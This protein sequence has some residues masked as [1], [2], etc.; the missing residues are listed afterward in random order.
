M[1]ADHDHQLDQREAG[2]GGVDRPGDK[3][4]SPGAAERDASAHIDAPPLV[5]EQRA[6]RRAPRPLC[7]GAN[8]T[9]V[10][11]LLALPA[12]RSPPERSRA[13]FF[14]ALL[15]LVMAAQTVGLAGSEAL[16]LAQLSARQ[17]PLAFVIASLAAVVGLG[18]LRGA[19]RAAR[20]DCAVRGRCCS[21]R[22]S[23]LVAVA[24]RHARARRAR[25]LRTDRRVL[26]DAL[27]LHEPLLDLRRRLLRHADQQAAR[28]RVRARLER[29]GAARRRARRGR[30]ARGRAARDDRRSGASCCARPRRCSRSR[31][32]R[33][34]AG[35]RWRRR[36]RRDQRRGHPRGRALRARVA[37]RA[38]AAARRRSG[39]CS[40]S[41]WRSTSTRTCSRAAT[42]TPTALAVFS[43][44]LSRALEPRRDRARAV[45]DAVADPALRRRGRARGASGAHARELRRA[46]RLGP[47]R[48]RDRRARQPRAD[49]QRRRAA[50]SHARVQ[51]AAAALPRPDSRVPRGHRRLRRDERGGPAPARARVAGSARA[52]AARRRRRA[53]L[54]RGQPRRAPRLSRHA[55]RRDPHRPPRPRRPRRRDRRLGGGQPRR[56]VRRAAARRVRCA[57]RAR[58]CS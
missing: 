1:I 25:A 37:A 20:N 43:G 22:A 51:R 31:G 53:R 27:R 41:S 34:G 21:A 45:G 30:R 32:A 47:A 58:C 23:L 11:A 35:G 4:N 38:L 46:V 50:R 42:P 56:A 6:P 52:R 44:R 3:T 17:L 48:H 13:L 7:C 29:R 54:S 39:W 2:R 18:D 24:A 9:A 33:C 15:T 14:I 5:P 57:R 26:P 12:G 49:R 55:D 8:A 36:S 16:F 28:A 19:S 40:R 10:R